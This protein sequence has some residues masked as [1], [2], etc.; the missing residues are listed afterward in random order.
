MRWRTH[1]DP[2]VS[3][4]PGVNKGRTCSAEGCTNQA[5]ARGLCGKHYQDQR[6]VE[7]GSRQCRRAGCTRLAV[8]DGLC[9]PHYDRRRRMDDEQELRDARR[10]SVEGCDRPYDAAGFCTMHYQRV[11]LN[12]EPGEVS[13]RRAPAGAGYV[14]NGYRIFW[15]EGG[16]R[17]AEHR[18]VMEKILGRPLWPWENVHHKNGRRADNRPENLELWITNQPAGQRIEDLVRFVAEHYPDE[19]RHVLAAM[20]G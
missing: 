12:G 11:R 14:H 15:R 7:N 18:L 1:G 13:V 2:E 20:E 8:L 19:V 4:R 3:L 5:H 6:A 16:K 17:V 10:C 9:K